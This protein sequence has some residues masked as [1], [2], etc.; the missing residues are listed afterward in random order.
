MLYQ[1][2]KESTWWYRF[3]FSG[4][5]VHESSK[6]QSR[7]VAR[8]AERQRRRELEEKWNRIEKRTLPPTFEKGS[9]DWLALQEGRVA[10]NTIAVAKI[11]LMHLREA[12]G[13]RLLCDIGAKDVA[14]YQQ[15]RLKDKAQ[16][17]T[18]NLELGV[19]RQIMKAYDCWSALDG[20]IKALP[21]RKNVGRALTPDDESLLLARCATSDSACYTATVLAINTTMRKDEIRKLRWNQVD[22]FDAALTV[23]KSKTQ[24]GTGRVIPLNPPAR[25]ALVDWANRFPDHE[26]AEYVF[27]WCEGGYTRKKRQES[28][29]FALS[30]S[31]QVDPTRPTKGWRTAW[32][33]VTRA[34]EC[35]KCGLLQP[36]ADVCQNLECNQEIKGIKSPLAGLRFHDLRHCAITKLAESQASDQT[37][38]SIAGHVSREMLEH[39]SHIRMAAKRAALDAIATRLPDLHGGKSPD[40]EGDVHQNGNQMGMSQ[41]VGAAKLLQ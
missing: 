21:I 12:F 39:Y 37:I 3:R 25:M 8:E 15:R 26:P 11:S 4:R 28:G 22:L 20:K 16:G 6:S 34:V 19:F 40:F 24:A 2:G 14:A 31:S 13:S 30:M 10:P 29:E 1:R 23:G 33:N 35:P 41:N 38:M 9:Q 17:K 18:V 27:P 7:T 36:P 5:I 32:R